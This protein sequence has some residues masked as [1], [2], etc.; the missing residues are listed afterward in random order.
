MAIILVKG[1]VGS[2]GSLS[3]ADLRGE[4]PVLLGSEKCHGCGPQRR[5]GTGNCTPSREGGGTDTLSRPPE[6]DEWLQGFIP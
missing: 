4:L 5:G 3:N 6:G 2:W 1:W